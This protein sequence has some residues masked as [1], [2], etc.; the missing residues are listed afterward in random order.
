VWCFSLLNICGTLK[1]VL[2]KKFWFLAILA[3]LLVIGFALVGCDNGMTDTR[4]NTGGGSSGSG[5]VILQNVSEYTSIDAVVTGYLYNSSGTL[6]S[7]SGG[8]SLRINQQVTWT[9]VPAGRYYCRVRDG[10]GVYYSSST[11]SVSSGQTVVMRFDGDYI[12]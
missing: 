1:E 10:R 5:T 12:R 8:T 11:F 7:S 9:N 3:L 4:G 6:V 2:M